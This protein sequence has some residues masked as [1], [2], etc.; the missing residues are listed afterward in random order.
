MQD[1]VFIVCF[2]GTLMVFAVDMLFVPGIKHVFCLSR[3][4]VFCSSFLFVKVLVAYEKC[5][6]RRNL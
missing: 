2:V 5:A 4:H 3:C 6:A 1:V